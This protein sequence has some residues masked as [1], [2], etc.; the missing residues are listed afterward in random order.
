[1]TYS[2]TRDDPD[3]LPGSGE[4]VVDLDGDRA[5]DHSRTEYVELHFLYRGPEADA[6][7]YMNTPELGESCQLHEDIPAGDAGAFTPFKIESPGENPT[8]TT[9]Q[10]VPCR[11]EYFAGKSCDVTRLE[12]VIEEQSLMLYHE[13]SI[14]PSPLSSEDGT[15]V[16][17]HVTLGRSEPDGVNES[18]WSLTS[19]DEPVLPSDIFDPICEPQEN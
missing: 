10:N 6:Y 16:I 14:L 8:V 11:S 4:N 15:V 9:L 5:T 3:Y 18:Y 12:V 1:M 7:V 2:I 17:E 13:Y 19:Y